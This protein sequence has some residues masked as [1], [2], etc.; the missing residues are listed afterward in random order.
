MRGNKVNVIKQKDIAVFH[1][2]NKV[3]I[4]ASITTANNQKVLIYDLK[5]KET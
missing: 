4:M 3:L 1:G 5:Q 2:P